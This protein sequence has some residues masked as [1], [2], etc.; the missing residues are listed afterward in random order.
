MPM[1]GTQSEKSDSKLGSTKAPNDGPAHY[2]LAPSSSSRWLACPFSAQDNLPDTAGPPAKAGTIGHKHAD[3]WLERNRDHSKFNPLWL[4]ETE[5]FDAVAPL[6]GKSKGDDI[7]MATTTYAAYVAA[8]PGEHVYETKIAHNAIK[9]FGGTVDT[10]IID[11]KESTLGVADF[12]S[13]YWEV[14]AKGNTQLQSY[15]VLARQQFG[16]FQNYTAT[17]VQPRVK[18]P[19]KT[20]SFSGA[21]LDAFE[22]LVKIA[23][24][25]DRIQ[26]GQHCRFCPLRPNCFEGQKYAATQEGWT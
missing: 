8:L 5:V 23:S 20:A 1:A 26:S 4:L 13:G 11:R 2:R 24:K 25:S 18:K 3:H 19:I 10:A 7:A 12:K 22:G 6:V 9:D 15:L 16:H 21:E 14:A 17:I